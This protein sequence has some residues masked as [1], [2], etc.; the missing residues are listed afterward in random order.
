MLADEL[1][2]K[3]RLIE[4]TTRKRV[5]DFMSGQYRSHFKGHG[6]QFSEHRLYV[7]GDDIRHID[8]KVSARTRDLLV[9]KYEEEREL[10]VF[11]I[12]DSSGS[13]A[14]GSEAKLK[15][16]VAAEI[17]GMLSYAASHT[18]DKVGALL[19]SGGVDLIIPPKKGRQHNLRIIR[20]IISHEPETKGTDLRGALDAAGRIMK[21]SGVVF[22]ISDFMA[23]DYAIALKRLARRHDVVAICV[24]DQR[25]LEIPEVGHFLFLDPETGAERFVDT[26]SYNFK[27]WVKNFREQHQSRRE[28]AMKGGKV[29]FLQLQ[30]KDDYGEA[31]VRFFR[32]RTRRQKR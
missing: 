23:D 21:H 14:F 11:L 13:G 32:A 18:G 3:V 30:T 22:V 15:S 16:E 8:W 5:D 19:F 9:K 7:P 10:T 4:I 20:D 1:L 25:E 28:A 6:V 26:S 12:V 24:S 27:N 17:A 31:V 29:E 2:R